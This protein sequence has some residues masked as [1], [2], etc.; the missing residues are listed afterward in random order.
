MRKFTSTGTF[1]AYHK[2][3]RPPATVKADFEVAIDDTKLV[4][5]ARKAYLNKAGK[6]KDGPVT[7]TIRNYTEVPIK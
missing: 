5:L 6:S 4:E 2:G 7:V 1:N 3:S